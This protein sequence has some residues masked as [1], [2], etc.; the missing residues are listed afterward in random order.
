MERRGRG[1]FSATATLRLE[2]ELR[3]SLEKW[4]EEE[5]RSV[6]SLIRLILRDAITARE[7]KSAAKRR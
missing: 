7:T 5:D 2:P 6:G 1:R 4:A 3:E